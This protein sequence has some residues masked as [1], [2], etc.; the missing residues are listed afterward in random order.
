MNVHVCTLKKLF[1][2]YCEQNVVH[3]INAKK[4]SVNLQ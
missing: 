4:S 1:S 3:Y 2:S